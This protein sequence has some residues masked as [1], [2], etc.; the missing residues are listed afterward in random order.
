MSS[1]QN[2]KILITGGLGFI[3]SNLAIMLVRQGASVVLVDNFLTGHGANLFNIQPIVS[4]V[5]W[6]QGD[7]RDADLIRSLVKD[8][9]L[10]FN[11]AA[12]T[13]HT[14]SLKDPF[15]DLD[16]NCRGNLVLL[17]ACRQ[18]NPQAKIVFIG[19][20]A[21]YGRPQ[22][23]PVNEQ[24]LVQPIDIYGINRYAAESYHLLYHRLYGLPIV[25][26]R[27]SNAYGP[28]GQMKTPTYGIHNWFIRLAIENQNIKIFGTG[29]Q[30]RDYL[31]IGDLVELLLK[32]GLMDNLFSGQVFNVG[33]GQP[34]ALVDLAQQILEISQSQ[35]QLEFVPWPKVNAKIDAG[36]FVTNITKIQQTIDWSPR[37][38]LATGLA[39]TIEYYKKYQQY[40]W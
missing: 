28:R 38:S 22:S 29:E 15:L 19:T 26:L 10:I 13:S 31:Y 30:K 35:G 32:I 9:D 37:I 20:R 25:S 21:F 1:Y 5:Q 6:L 17:E 23:V 12:Q 18:Q 16:I 3:G 36:D 33:Y 11:I 7:L 34:V 8:K 24:A 40:Y 14:E 27:L 4:Q 2:K 39:R